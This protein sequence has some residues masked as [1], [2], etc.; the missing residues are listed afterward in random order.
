MKSIIFFLF[1]LMSLAISAQTILLNQTFTTSTSITPFVGI[2][3]ISSLTITG[4][5]T[6]LNDTGIVRVILIDNNLNEYL[7]YEGHLFSMNGS[8]MTFT[9]YTDETKYL[10]NI[11]PTSIL[12]IAKNA[13]VT[14]SAIQYVTTSSAYTTTQIQALTENYYKSMIDARIAIMNSRLSQ[15]GYTWTASA[16]SNSYLTYMTKRNAFGFGSDDYNNYSIEHYRNGPLD[17]PPL[18]ITSSSG[19][20]SNLVS[21][22]NSWDWRNRHN[23]T[24]PSS[25]YFNSNHDS[26]G[27][28]TGAKN[29][30]NEICGSCVIFSSVGM[31]ENIM[32]LY[33][34]RHIDYDLSEQAIISCNNMGFTRCFPDSGFWYPR[35]Y[36]TDTGLIKESCY[37][38]IQ[39]QTQIIPNCSTKKTAYNNCS[40]K[41]I[42]KVNRNYFKSSYL[43]SHSNLMKRLLVKN[44]PIRVFDK[45]HS[46]LLIGWKTIS[47]KTVWIVKNSL[48]TEIGDKG[49][50]EYAEDEISIDETMKQKVYKSTKLPEC[51]DIDR[52]G[53]YTWQGNKPRTCPD[54][55]P[56]VKDQDDNNNK[57]GP[58]DATLPFPL[59]IVS[60]TIK[61]GFVDWKEPH[62][63][64]G[65][66]I[67]Y[68][69]RSFSLY[70]TIILQPTAK[71]I[72]KNGARVNINDIGLIKSGS[73]IVETG[74]I[75]N[76][77]GEIVINPNYATFPTYDFNAPYFT[78][79]VYKESDRVCVDM[80]GDGYYNWG[81]GD[82]PA[83]CPSCAPDLEDANDWSKDIV[84]IDEYGNAIAFTP[85]SLGSTL[86]TNTQTWNT[87]TIFCG[88]INIKNNS[89]LTLS[90]NG[91]IR[92]QA[93]HKIYVE[94]GSTLTI[95]GGKTTL[96]GIVVKSGGTLNL[97]N[98]GIIEIV[99]PAA[100]S[101][102]LGGIFNQTYGSVNIVNPF[103]AK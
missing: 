24:D 39:G 20:K 15:L 2:N 13:T 7:L 80:D 46:T 51:A 65:N 103:A 83:T 61:S 54:N 69:S 5:A 33:Y 77:D 9:T 32:N 48:G 79:N 28:M 49:F 58:A 90:S 30:H 8:T 93:S 3:S 12:M 55:I 14:L 19:L 78:S 102:E 82:K 62:Y 101:I 18:S 4:S 41:D 86:V 68:S 16:Q 11:K 73:I 60:D 84:A 66:L 95:N 94:S 44:G 52:D 22:P 26:Y 31:V 72:I 29:Q 91:I 97:I 10:N 25:P 21:T 88:D 64:K 98:N 85:L 23:A 67:I 50:T 89:T 71:I 36:L 96:A 27:W 99:N 47:D 63:L 59:A 100:V 92:M 87:E 57:I 37:P 74:G 35:V 45:C 81:I 34:N 53:Y 70:D 1:V 40:D 17:R 43:N 76:N 38:Y 42:V 75:L 56:A 6:L